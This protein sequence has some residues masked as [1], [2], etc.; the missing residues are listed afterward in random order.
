MITFVIFLSLTLSTQ[1]QEIQKNELLCKKVDY[2]S[3]KKARLNRADL[4]KNNL[5][6][7]PNF[8]KKF[9][10]MNIEYAMETAWY[11]VDCETGKFIPDVLY[12]SLPLKQAIFKADSDTIRF[13]D[14]KNPRTILE[15][16]RFKDNQWFKTNVDSDKNNTELFSVYPVKNADIIGACKTPDFTTYERADSYKKSIC[17]LNPDLTHP[18]FH[19]HFLMLRAESIFESY[20]LIVDCNTGKFSRTILPGIAQFKKDSRLL[21]IFNNGSHPKHFLWL[22]EDQQWVEIRTYESANAPIKNTIY[23]NS[24]RRLFDSTPN[25]DKRDIV[26][27]ENLKWNDGITI[28]SGKCMNE[29]GSPRCDIEF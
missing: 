13:S 16:H 27:F 29:T 23:G 18:N 10:L 22:E 15:A 9:Q 2:D 25:P 26:R 3:Y 14:L 17:S 20:W 1:A 24:A 4:E 28:V 12:T 6:S 8:S 7:L 19:G 11:L 5:G 21:K